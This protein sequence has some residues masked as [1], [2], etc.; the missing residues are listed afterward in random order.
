MGW[1]SALGSFLLLWDVGH[2]RTAQRCL[3]RSMS[4]GPVA[5]HITICSQ[6]L[7]EFECENWV[8]GHH[9]GLRRRLGIDM[10]HLC[11]LLDIWCKARRGCKGQPKAACGRRG[12]LLSFD[13]SHRNRCSCYS[14]LN[15]PPLILTFCVE[16]THTN[17]T[18]WLGR[19]VWGYQLGAFWLVLGTSLSL[20]FKGD[21]FLA[22]L[23]KETFVKKYRL[24][25]EPMCNVLCSWYTRG[26]SQGS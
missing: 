20:H 21:A 3:K 11:I 24:L 14:Q 19:A 4:C 16:F 26:C 12:V 5:D 2:L 7:G 8:M 1:G 15:F 23:F 10:K 9:W 25:I 6:L 18:H 22:A 13:L 17:S